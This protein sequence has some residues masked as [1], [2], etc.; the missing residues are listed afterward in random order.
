[1]ATIIHLKRIKF[2][3]D[4]FGYRY[5]VTLSDGR[6]GEISDE[7]IMGMFEDFRTETP[8][9]RK[10]LEGRK[11]NEGYSLLNHKQLEEI[12]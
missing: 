4:Q 11:W 2:S 6:V 12:F 9:S 5:I 7:Q 8:P 1:M 10:T 3:Q